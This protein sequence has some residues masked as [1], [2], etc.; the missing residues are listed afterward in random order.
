MA[1]GMP[2][3]HANDTH[4]RAL[5]RAATTDFS[6]VRSDGF[7]N[8]LGRQS[9]GLLGFPDSPGGLTNAHNLRSAKSYADLRSYTPSPVPSTASFPAALTNNLARF[10]EYGATSTGASNP[11]LTSTSTTLAGREESL[12]VN[13]ISSMNLGNS[14]G[15]PGG[16]P[17]SI[18]NA[19]DREGPGPIGGHRSFSTANQSLEDQSR[20]GSQTMPQRQPRGPAPERG[21][22]FGRQARQN[23]HNSQR[24]SDELSSQPGGVEI[25]VEQ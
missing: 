5:N 8:T 25:L 18:R 3:G 21:P 23:G 6:D 17:R 16:S 11:N 22:G 20:G 12:L 15:G 1:P 2:P 13:G 9:S 7:Y 19:W 10:A 4:R 24:T 14:F